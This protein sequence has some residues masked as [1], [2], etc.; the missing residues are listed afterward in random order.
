MMGGANATL[1]KDDATIAMERDERIGE[2]LVKEL[3]AACIAAG[4][5]GGSVGNPEAVVGYMVARI[6]AAAEDLGKDDKARTIAR[7]RSLLD[8]FERC[9]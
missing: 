3:S 1:G 8:I 4:F 2:M 6:I 9:R 5:V 7:Y